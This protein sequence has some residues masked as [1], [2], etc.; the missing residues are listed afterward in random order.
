[1]R[2][3]Q[4]TDTILLLLSLALIFTTGY[5]RW[6]T[7]NATDQPLIIMIDDELYNDAD[8]TADFD[9]SLLINKTISFKEKVGSTPKYGWESH[10]VSSV[11]NIEEFW[12]IIDN[13]EMPNVVKGLAKLISQGTYDELVEAY[14]LTRTQI[15][16]GVD[17][18]QI[19]MGMGDTNGV[20][21]TIYRVEETEDYAETFDLEKSYGQIHGPLY[22]RLSRKF[23]T[24]PYEV[25]FL[26][27][28]T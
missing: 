1:M 18:T 21:Y 20:W 8:F 17:E 19:Y 10:E 26:R 6:V 14:N 16:M 3:F 13:L 27:E 25:T 28:K 24:P 23:S 5:W 22:W 7:E 12:E 11:K 4:R 9:Y 15:Y 2:I